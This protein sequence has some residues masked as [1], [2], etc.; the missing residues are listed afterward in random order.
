MIGMAV[1][2]EVVVRRIGVKAV[3]HR[4]GFTGQVGAPPADELLHGREIVPVHLLRVIGLHDAAGPVAAGLDPG[5]AHL[6]HAVEGIGGVVIDHVGHG[7]RLVRD[8][9]RLREV[10][11][12][13]P[14]NHQ[15]GIDPQRVQPLSRPSSRRQ[16]ETVTRPGPAVRRP[17]LHAVFARIDRDDFRLRQRLHAVFPDAVPQTPYHLVG[18]EHRAVGLVDGFAVPRQVQLGETA[19]K[20]GTGQSLVGEFAV[21]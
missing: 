17:Y 1:Q 8:R 6:G 13:L 2:D 16:H 11:Q 5:H 18:E 7:A 19:R 20:G 21:Q 12:Q 15:L 14:R 10:G 4:D 3:F 9:V